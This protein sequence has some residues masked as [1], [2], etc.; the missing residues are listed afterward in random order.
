MR[1]L[2]NMA[3]KLAANLSFLFK[4]QPLLERFE[5]ASRNGFNGVEFG[6]DVVSTSSKEELVMAKERAG[7]EVVGL[8]GPN[9]APGEY[10]VAAVPG[11]EE[12]FKTFLSTAI[13]YAVALKCPRVHMLTGAVDPSIRDNAEQT[14]IANLKHA[15][16]ECAKHNI[17][18][19][20][21]PIS[22][23]PNYFLTHQQQAVDIL[24]KVDY[25][26]VK[27]EFDVFHAQR[28]DGNLTEFLRSHLQYVDHIQ[29]S[30]V[31]GRHEPDEKGEVN[32]PFFI[33]ALQSMGYQGWLACEYIPATTTEEG[34]HWT[35]N[36]IGK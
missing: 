5:A 11:R 35:K 12:D 34:L 30:Q 36:Y 23:I 28:M 1:N 2:G 10:G 22:V 33:D 32:F 17:T 13:E 18:V 6:A 3:L 7:V 8:C 9:G 14:F 31:P 24:K 29:I 4:E 26:N 27:L 25:P 20:I 19:L 15:A 16:Q 21:E